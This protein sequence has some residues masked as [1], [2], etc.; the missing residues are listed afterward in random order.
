VSQKLSVQAHGLCA[1][2][3]FQRFVDRKRGLLDKTTGY[4][5]AA[6]FVR[7]YCGVKSRGD[8]DYVAECGGKFK[9][10]RSEYRQTIAGA[11]I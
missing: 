4:D 11:S 3:S 5:G 7:D 1:T 10:L 2:E 9:A 8:L 6:Q